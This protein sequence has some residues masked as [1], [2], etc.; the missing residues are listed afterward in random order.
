MNEVNDQGRLLY[1]MNPLKRFSQRATYYARYRPT[2]PDEAITKVIANLGNYNTPTAA[3]IGAGTGISARLLASQGINVMAIE[4]N[5]EMKQAAI[6]HPQVKFITG[7]A[8]QTNLPDKSVDL[9]TAFQAFH[10]FNPELALLEF[11]RILKPSGRLAI[12]WNHRNRKD[13]FTQEYSQVL[14]S[15]SKDHPAEKEKRRKSI[16]FL[17]E[18]SYFI[19]FRYCAIPHQQQLDLPGLMGRTQSAS[20]IPVEGIAAE[21]I[22]DSLEKLYDK[23]KD[24]QGFVY[25]IYR[26]DVYLAE[27][28]YNF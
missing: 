12:I 28:R 24:R 13:G 27:S 23:W 5:A 1:R 14:K 3:D 19:N 22:I 26:T 17:E 6:A 16:S 7:T 2:Y 11:H 18:S 25:I 20:Y 8:E 9:V 4:P 15:A 10:W 21:K